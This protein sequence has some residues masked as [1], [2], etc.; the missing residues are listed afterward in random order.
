VKNASN[1]NMSFK[2]QVYELTWLDPIDLILVK[3]PK[4]PIFYFLYCL[5]SLGWMTRRP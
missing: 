2:I 1:S 3:Y 4:N 5:F